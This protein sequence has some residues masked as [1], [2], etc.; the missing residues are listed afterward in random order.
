MR[1]GEFANV[2]PAQVVAARKHHGL[3]QTQFALLASSAIYKGKGGLQARRLQ[4]WEAGH[5]RVPL[6]N[7]ELLQV[8]L[9]LL[10]RK[11]ATFEELAYQPLVELVQRNIDLT[12]KADSRTHLIAGDLSG[13]RPIEK[14]LCPHGYDTHELDLGNEICDKCEGI[15][16]CTAEFPNV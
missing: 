5:C 2:E 10:E 15:R 3:T 7:W 6:A 14:K 16:M 9:H 11:L 13:V 8:R 12:E 1:H 4:A